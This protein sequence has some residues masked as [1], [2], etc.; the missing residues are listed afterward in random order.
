MR[1][2]GATHLFEWKNGA[3]HLFTGRMVPPTYSNESIC[4][5]VT[6][7]L[8]CWVAPDFRQISIRRERC[9][10]RPICEQSFESPIRCLSPKALLAWAPQLPLSTFAP[11]AGIEV[12]VFG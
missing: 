11:G 2:N 5:R 4:Q 7:S 8:R 3:T 12:A 9:S 6:G 10:G 1:K